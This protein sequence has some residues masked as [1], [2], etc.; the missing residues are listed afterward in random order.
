MAGAFAGASRAAAAGREGREPAATPLRD[1]SDGVEQRRGAA[2]CFVGDVLRPI[3]ALACQLAPERGVS[4]VFVAVDGDELPGVRA[5]DGVLREAVTNLVDNAIKYCEPYGAPDA[6]ADGAHDGERRPSVE[7][8]AAAT[9]ERRDAPSEPAAAAA[10]G[11]YVAVG[12]E[13]DPALGKVRIQ[14][15]NSGAPLTDDDSTFAFEWGVRGRAASL[16]EVEGSGYGLPIASQL[17]ALIGGELELYNAPMPVWAWRRLTDG[18]TGDG[19][20]MAV[21][22]ATADHR[23]EPEPEPPSPS[24]SAGA[25]G[26]AGAARPKQRPTGVLAQILLPRA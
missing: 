26:A 23:P 8:A 21:E 18:D 2:L 17:V 3:A 11:R 16:N 25:V 1:D 20:T 4:A 12:C 10:L 22:A 7:P 14:V 19:L 5:A 15:W 24:A 9:D 13:W 6:T